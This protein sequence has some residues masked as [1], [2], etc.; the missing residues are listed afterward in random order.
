MIQLAVAITNPWSQRFRLIRSWYG[1]VGRHKAWEFTAYATNDIV[2][3][4]L[5][6]QIRCDHA[7]INLELGLLGFAVELAFCDSRHWNDAKGCW[8]SY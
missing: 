4:E 7:G 6:W 3:A 1:R 8:R 5:R 2:R